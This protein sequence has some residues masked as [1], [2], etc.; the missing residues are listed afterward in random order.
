MPYQMKLAWQNTTKGDINK[1]TWMNGK[2]NVFRLSN[3]FTSP[4]GKEIGDGDHAASLF[5]KSTIEIPAKSASPFEGKVF[6]TIEY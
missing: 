2:N 3:N 5:M 4:D 1:L 6:L